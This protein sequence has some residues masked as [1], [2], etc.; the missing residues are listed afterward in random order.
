[1]NKELLKRFS[2]TAF[3]LLPYP[4]RIKE[5]VTPKFSW[6]YFNIFLSCKFECI[7]TI[8]IVRYHEAMSYYGI[9]ITGRNIHLM[10]V[11]TL[12]GIHVFL[13]PACA[14]D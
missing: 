14:K 12:V 1:M 9:Q 8:G 10:F 13:F 4:R 2:F 6:P 3:L 7:L 11:P 5:L